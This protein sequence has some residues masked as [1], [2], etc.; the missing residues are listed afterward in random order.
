MNI[1][2]PAQNKKK[3]ETLFRNPSLKEKT[4]RKE[5][6]NAIFLSQ[7]YSTTCCSKH[8]PTLDSPLIIDLYNIE[9]TFPKNALYTAASLKSGQHILDQ[10]IAILDTAGQADKIVK[11]TDGFSLLNWDTGVG[12]GSWN[13]AEGLDTTKGLGKGEDLGLL[14]EL[15]GGGTSGSNTEGEHTTVGVLAVLLES[16]LA[17]RV[18][19]KTWVVD[20]GDEGGGLES[21]G[22]LGGV[23]RGLAGTEME[24]L[25]TTVGEPRVEGG[26]DGADGVLEESETLSESIIVESGNTHDNVGVTVDVLG[27]G[28]DDN[29]G[30]MGQW[31]LDVWGHEGVVDDDNDS[32]G[33]CNLCDGSDIDEG[34]SWVRWG[35]DPDQLG[36]ALLDQRL[37]IDLNV[38]SEGNLNIV[39]VSNLGEVSVGSSVNVRNGDNVGVEWEGLEDHSGGSG[40]GGKGQSVLGSLERGHGILKLVSVWV[41]GSRVLVNSSWDSDLWLSIGCGKRDLRRDL[42][43]LDYVRR[44]E[45]VAIFKIGR[46]KKWAIEETRKKK[47]CLGSPVV[48]GSRVVARVARI[49]G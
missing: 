21:S 34:E 42:L 8:T 18:G 24:G 48:V 41:C 43:G 16:N 40:S 3:P 1:P 17:L 13:L 45:Y 5:H 44:L 27:D 46:Q 4:A 47:V 49:W 38:S 10:V 20:E 19:V 35:L 25:E 28:V 39:G 36:A 33:L 22:D 37:D 23:L 31:G 11:H 12:H 32:V 7:V 30:S 2:Y 29:V 9:T 14:A 6:Q 26:W 15:S